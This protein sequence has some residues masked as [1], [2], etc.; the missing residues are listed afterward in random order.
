MLNSYQWTYSGEGTGVGDQGAGSDGASLSTTYYPLSTSWLPTGGLMPITDTTGVNRC[1]AL[2]RHVRPRP[3]KL[4]H[5]CRRHGQLQLRSNRAVD[6]SNLHVPKSRVLH[7]KENKRSEN[8]RGQN[9]R[10]TKGGTK[11]VGNKRGRESLF[12]T[13]REEYGSFR[14]CHDNCELPAEDMPTTC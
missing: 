7:L 8:K 9:K 14:P 10:G 12:L 6:L 4:L 2:R 3:T 1:V 5:V 11:G 13:V